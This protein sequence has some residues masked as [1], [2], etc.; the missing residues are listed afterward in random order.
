MKGRI[1]DTHELHFKS[2][3]EKW[4]TLWPRELCR[5]SQ[6]TTRLQVCHL[7]KVLML[8]TGAL[9]SRFW[10]QISLILHF[11]GDFN[12]KLNE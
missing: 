5:I 9:S 4:D 8:I 3:N 10:S 12:E 11:Q 2:Q 1:E 6:I 7:G